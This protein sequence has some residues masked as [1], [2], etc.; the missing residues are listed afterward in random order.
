M[1][2]DTL[3][4]LDTHSEAV[5]EVL[6][7]LYAMQEFD[8][9]AN[10]Y[11]NIGKDVFV[12][13]HSEP[14]LTCTYEADAVHIARML[15]AAPKLV[16]ELLALEELQKLQELRSSC[17]VERA[18]VLDRASFYLSVMC[19]NKTSCFECPALDSCKKPAGKK[20]PK[21]H[22]ILKEWYTKQAKKELCIG[23]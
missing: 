14:I 20:H 8:G 5:R 19:G 4:K 21:C 18:S 6:P 22:D 9:E 23:L 11:V 15:N 10:N 17:A 1:K 3:E 13:G 12:E 16:M 2:R 7:S